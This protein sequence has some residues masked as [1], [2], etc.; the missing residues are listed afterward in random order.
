MNY[1]KETLTKNDEYTRQSTLV[2]LVTISYRWIL[3][4]RR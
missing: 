1:I 3:F 2:I 4:N